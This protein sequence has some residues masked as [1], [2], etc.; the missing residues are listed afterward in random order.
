MS[1]SAGRR[2]VFGLAL[3]LAAIAQVAL[4]MPAQ[5]AGPYQYFAVTPCRVADTRHPNGVDGGPVLQGG[6]WRGFNIKGFCGVPNTAAAVTL[7]VTITQPAVTV[8][9][10]WL[11]LVPAGGSFGGI[12]NINFT[13][14]DGSLANGAIVPLAAGAQDLSI[15]LGANSSDTVHV[16]LDV[17]GY[18]Q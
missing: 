14:A 10:A 12:S 15:L 5:A 8:G 18:F 16:I 4:S 17:T 6:Q 1:R 13:N 2:T 11:A 9:T 3:L 7:N